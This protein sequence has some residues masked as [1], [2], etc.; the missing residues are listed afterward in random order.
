MTKLKVDE[1]KPYNSLFKHI[2]CLISQIF[3]I[4]NVVFVKCI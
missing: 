4:N 1:K 3:L 2:F